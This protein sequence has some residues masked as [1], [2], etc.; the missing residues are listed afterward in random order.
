M[1]DFPLSHDIGFQ[2]NCSY[3]NAYRITG[4]QQ[5]RH[6]IEAAADAL[7]GRFNPVV[8]AT[9]SWA[10]GE[11]GEYPVIIDNMMNLELL[12]YASKL[13]SSDTLQSIAVTHAETTIANHFRQDYSSWHMLDYNPSTGEVMRRV[14]VQGLS[15][16]SAWARGQ[17]WALY[18][19]TMMF[20]ETGREEFL[21]QA[22]K[23]A[24][25][26]LPRLPYDGIPYWDF[27]D[28]EIPFAYRDASAGAIMSSAFVELSALTSD[29]KL[30]KSCLRMAEKQ[31]RTLASPEYLADV[32]T[33]GDFLLKHSV[34]NLP[35]GSEIDVPLPYADY[36]FLEAIN[37]YK[38]LK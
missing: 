9:L 2:V 5:Y 24:G 29:R 7:A 6:L 10:A 27:D 16:G 15:D 23:I 30:A 22:E 17:A 11:K 31:I 18:G 8:G 37:R 14:T 19:Y 36:Y 12:E 26:L 20:R 13:F 25:M 3:G 34:G 21:T 1:L 28:P 4:D 32:G 38:T 33:N 35:G